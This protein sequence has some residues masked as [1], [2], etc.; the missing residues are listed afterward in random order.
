MNSIDVTKLKKL[1]KDDLFKRDIFGRTILHICILVNNS[2][3]LKSLTKNPDFKTLLKLNDYENGWNCLHYIFFHKRLQC[4][5]VLIDYLQGTIVQGNIFATNSPLLELLK[6]KDRN[7]HT[8]LNLLNN[9]FKDLL[10][11]P[12]YITDKNEFHMTYKYER[13]KSTKDVVQ[14]EYEPDTLPFLKSSEILWTDKRGASEIYVFGCN[15][16]NQLGVGDST[17]R[18]TPALLYHDN[19]KFATDLTG[20]ISERF[21]RPRYKRITISKNHSVVVTQDGELFSCG[22]GSRG[23]L[24]HGLTDLNNYFKFKRIEFF[25]DKT[26]KDVAISSNHSIA[27]TTDNEVYAWGL[28]SFNQ[29]G[30][31]NMNNKKSTNYLDK[32]IATPIMVGGELRKMQNIIGIEV[33][34]IHSLAWSKNYLCFWGLNVGQMGISYTNGDI[35]VKVQERS[36]RGETQVNPK[37]IQ[38]RDDIKC[39]ST[40]ELCTCVVTTL[41]DVHV[42]YNYQHFK[43]PKIP[44]KGHGDKHFDYFKPRRITEAAVI[45]KI[46]TRGPENSMILLKNGSVF[47][48]SVNANDIKNTKYTSIWKAYDHD[49]VATDIDISTDGSVVLCTRS[50]TVFIKSTLSSNQRKNSMSGATLPIPL[51][52]NKFK[53]IENVNNVVRVTC[54]P[55]FLSFGF[56]RDDIDLLPL[57][58]PQNDFFTDIETLSPAVEYNFNRK[59]N[60]LFDTQDHL[61]IANFF[62][63]SRNNTHEDDADDAEYDKLYSNQDASVINKIEE[64]YNSK[65]DPRASK[66]VKAL[67]TYENIVSEEVYSTI[68]RCSGYG[69]DYV[70]GLKDI[71]SNNENLFDANFEFAFAQ[72]AKFGFHSRVLE[73]R[74]SVFQK[75]LQLNDKN[76]TL[77]GDNIKIVW[78]PEQ[79]TLRV[80]TT[81]SP[82]A[83]L[84]FM[85]SVYSGRKMDNLEQN[86]FSYSSP[87]LV[88]L[89]I[90]QY[91]SLCSLFGIGCDRLSVTDAFQ[92]LL[93]SNTGDVVIKASDG[94]VF[95]HAFVLKARSAFFETL[96]SERWDTEKKGNVQYVDFTGLTKFQVTL[97]LRHLY[98]VSNESLLDCFQYD[99]GE[100]DYFINDLLELIEVADELLLFQLKSVLQ[101]AICDMISLDNVLVLLVHGF[102]LN[103]RQLFL[104]CCWYIFNNLEVLMFAPGFKE[105]PNGTMQLLEVFI[106]KLGNVQNGTKNW[107]DQNPNILLEHIENI[108]EFNEYFMSDRKGFSSFKPLIDNGYIDAIKTKETVKKR[109]SRKSSTSAFNKDISDFRQGLRREN[110]GES[111]PPTIIDE[112][113]GFI[114]VENKTKQRNASSSSPNILNMNGIVEPTNKIGNLSVIGKLASIHPNPESFVQSSGLPSTSNWATKPQSSSIE[115]NTLLPAAISTTLT[116]AKSKPTKVKIG[117]V[118]KLSQKQ[119]KRLAAAAAA[120]DANLEQIDQKTTKESSTIAPWSICVADTPTSNSQNINNLPAL[121]SSKPKKKFISISRPQST[122]KSPSPISIP[123]STASTPFSMAAAIT[124]DSSFNSVYSTPSLTEVMIHESLKLEQA[125]LQETE[126]KTL[127]EIQQEQ[128]FAKWWEEESKRVQEEMQR[129]E[130]ADTKKKKKKKNTSPKPQKYRKPI[131]SDS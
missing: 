31:P 110:N 10:W 117:P 106:D 131:K 25:N 92:D 19:F 29:L 16:N 52:K 6:F 67:S 18:A 40:S 7:G 53:K 64:I 21:K 50:G 11:F 2:D 112:N 57:E 118:T 125:K 47:S 83:A 121:G 79:S 20:S 34:K 109:K 91:Q 119:R 82:V 85:H 12:E 15:S 49:M 86:V 37:A 54:D 3:A 38:L 28:N 103:A 124:P 127:V 9:D 55:K 96:L 17:D 65:F 46:V 14:P 89:R 60:K 45:K 108:E 72:D 99:F 59:Q 69:E 68:K 95:A 75:L 104:N 88:R 43:L 100:K 114:L 78:I 93:N 42:Y 56:M 36:V 94:D 73:F 32:F 90:N 33:S 71:L 77:I 101:L 58:L 84:M 123:S 1:A 27:L 30:V 22:V 130:V 116:T 44:M 35:E 97:I 76:E 113:D 81:I 120:N 128:E 107:I 63:A 87:E 74:S 66:R 70:D 61:Y 105:I 111:F 24:G 51:T 5:K 8:P 126:R 80:L 102:T 26:I 48:F 13:I 4:L 62:T 98:G 129:L 23:R 122:K 115:S 39:V 41:N